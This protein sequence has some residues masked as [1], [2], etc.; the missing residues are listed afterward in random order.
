MFKIVLQGLLAQKLRLVT[1]ALA[2]MLGRRVHGG[3]AGAHR[4][5]RAAPSTTCSPASTRA[6]TPSSG[7]RP[8]STGRTTSAKQRPR[9]TPR[10][11]TALRRVPGVAAAEGSVLGLHPADRQGRQ[12]RSATRPAARPRWAATGAT[13]PGAQPVPPGGRARPAGADEVVIDKKSATDGHLAVGDTTTVLVNGPPQRVRITGIVGVRHRRQ[14]GRRVG[15]A[16]HHAAS[17]SGSSR[18]PGQVRRDLLRRRAGRVAAAA[19]QQPAARAAAR[20][21]GGHRRGGHQGNPGPVRRRSC[22][23]ST[24]SCWSSPSSRCWSAPS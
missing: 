12:A 24:R 15:R 10:W 11:S 3:D 17:R 16:V 21:R 7:P 5:H 13:R 9:S 2:V 4:H 14:P 19:G 20:R 22:R 23:S 18:Q 6:P 8:S 1:T